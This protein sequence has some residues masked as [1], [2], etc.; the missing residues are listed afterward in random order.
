MK[1]L[2][3]IASIAAA[4]LAGGCT[5]APSENEGS[6]QEQQTSAPTTE[7]TAS[8]QPGNEATPAP[9]APQAGNGTTGEDGQA[10]TFATPKDAASAVITA[11]KNKD[12]KALNAYVHPEN[13]LRFSPYAHIDSESAV[14]FGPGKL[15]ELNDDTVYTWGA[16][17][18]SGEPIKLTFGQYYDRFVYDHDYANPQETGWDTILG[19]GNTT[20]NMK[21][22]YPDSYVVDY[23]FKGFDE[24]NEGMDWASLILVLQEHEGGWYVSAI[25]HSG[26]TI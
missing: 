12:I 9:T 16:Y 3:L 7:P 15:P 25:A 6:G 23:H 18:G 21:E 22:I 5:N 8:A 17:D 11:L 4:V 13:G 20:P 2:I 24:K 19:S 1:K 14:H 10:Q 26:W